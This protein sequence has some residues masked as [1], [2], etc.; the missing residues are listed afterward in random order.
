MTKPTRMIEVPASVP[1]APARRPITL[2]RAALEAARPRQWAKNLLVFAAPLAGASLGRDH[3]LGYALLAAAAFTGASAAVYLINDIVDADR[4]RRHASKRN[5]PVASGRLPAGLA[6]GVA[7]IALAF[8]FS[9]CALTGSAQLAAVVGIY[10]AI[11]LA[12]TMLLKHVPGV[13]VA[14]VAIGFMLRVL[15]GAVATGVPPSGYFLAVCSLGALTVALSKRYTEMAVLGPDAPKHRPVLR[16]YRLPVLRLSQRV[17]A[18]AM[19]CCYLL[20]AWSEAAA[21]MRTW[22]LISAAPLAVALSRFDRLTGLAEDKPVEDLITR[23][24]AM[25][26]AEVTWLTLFLVGL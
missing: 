24:P 26:C 10:V 3:E 6:A 2:I 4:D 5:R 23:D 1:A 8:A 14:F 11:S 16:W 12:Y 20:W 18:V 22:H 13:E 25:T 17:T 21:W 19:F 7:G 9:A 15:A